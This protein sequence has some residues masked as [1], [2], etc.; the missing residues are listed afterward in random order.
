[1][2]HKLGRIGLVS[3]QGKPNRRFKAGIRP[4]TVVVVICAVLGAAGT[5]AETL[6]W[7][8]RT[9]PLAVAPPALILLAISAQL[10][11]ALRAVLTWFA[12]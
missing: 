8:P 11:A 2:D 1:M 4:W 5:A 7:L 9:G 3:W 6:G 10:V 12:N